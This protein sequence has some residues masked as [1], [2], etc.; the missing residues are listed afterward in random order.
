MKVR[1]FVSKSGKTYVKF[2]RQMKSESK[3]ALL[4]YARIGADEKFLARYMPD[5]AGLYLEENRPFPE[6]S[7]L[8]AKDELDNPV[9][10]PFTL[11]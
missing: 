2:P 9:E 11:V 1:T 6:G 3:E 5:M 10:S 7:I 4:I 8:V